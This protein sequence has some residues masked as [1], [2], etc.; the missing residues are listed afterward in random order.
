MSEP[1]AERRRQQKSGSAPPPKRDP[2]IAVYVGLA[3]VI[4]LVFVG[5]GVARWYQTHMRQQVLSFEL[6]TPSPA[7]SPTEK[8][9]M[10]NPG[11]AVGQIDSRL[12]ATDAAHGRLPDTITGG[13]GQPVDGIPCELTE[14]VVLHIH[15]HLTIVD[16]GKV[17]QVP[18]LIGIE[19]TMNGQACLYWLHTHD[20]SGTIHVESASVLAPK[21][22]PFTL[23]MFFDV[24]GQPLTRTQVA[25]LHGNVTAYVNTQRYTGDLRA[26][27]LRSHEDITLEVGTPVIPPP[28]YQLPASE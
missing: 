5:F 15:T 24:W 28:N 10:V 12:P 16:H 3:V 20:A 9:I 27:P 6:A 19:P 7:P 4:A 18:A 25:T 26:I 22:G 14:Q 8:P 2:M 17:I 21:G 1:R 11:K 23:G 13:K